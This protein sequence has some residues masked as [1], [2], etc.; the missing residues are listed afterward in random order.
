MVVKFYFSFVLTYSLIANSV[1]SNVI[2][3][4]CVYVLFYHSQ[5]RET[6]PPAY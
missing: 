2:V 1:A 3:I 5:Q 4:L 6:S